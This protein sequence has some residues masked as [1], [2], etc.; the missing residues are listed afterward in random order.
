M[1]SSS[2]ALLPAL[3]L[4][5][6]VV[7]WSGL[8]PQLL[9]FNET[10][11]TSAFAATALDLHVLT[12][13]CLAEHPSKNYQHLQICKLNVNLLVNLRLDCGKLA[14]HRILA[15]ELT[16]RAIVHLNLRKES[17]PLDLNGEVGVGGALKNLAHSAPRW[18]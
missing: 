18:T 1:T 7:L 6:A 16:S 2:L 11:S 8:N 10:S 4:L 14:H 13:L 17:E 9:L 5:F 3:D 15:A 12:Q